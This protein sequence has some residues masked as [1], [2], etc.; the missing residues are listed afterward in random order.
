MT[1]VR[2][3]VPVIVSLHCGIHISIPLFAFCLPQAM[4]ITHLNITANS[5]FMNRCGSLKSD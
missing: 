5:H 3:G 1:L 2:V 4:L